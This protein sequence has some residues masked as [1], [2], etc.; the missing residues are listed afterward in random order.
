M[1]VFV[2]VDPVSLVRDHSLK[3]KLVELGFSVQS[4]N[5]D[6]LF[7]PWEV[8]DEDGHAFTTFEAYWRKCLMLPMEPV[9]L[10][11]PWRLSPASGKIVFGLGFTS[12]FSGCFSS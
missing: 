8:Y 10:L 5:G 12:F 9:S 4:F 7:E 11:P 3:E 2:R 1:G 6:L